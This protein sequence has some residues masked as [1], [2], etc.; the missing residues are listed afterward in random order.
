[1]TKEMN[2]T[3]ISEFTKE[4]IVSA[5]KQMHPTKAPGPDGMPAL[6]YKIFWHIIEHD[7]TKLCLSMLKGQSQF[8]EINQTHIILIPKV[9][10]PKHI[11]QFRPI[12]LCNVVYK[13]IAKVLAN[14]LKVVLPECISNTQSAFFP[15]KLITDNALVA[16]ELFHTFKNKRRG[17]KGSYA[18][19]LDMTKAYDRVEWH[20]LEAMMRKVFSFQM[21]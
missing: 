13:I 9:K 21:D 6:F 10:N 3:L 19:K 18:L 7:V 14:R 5:N 8:H 12:N 17:S 16:F 11:S 1:M 15:D 4:E 20:F 2:D